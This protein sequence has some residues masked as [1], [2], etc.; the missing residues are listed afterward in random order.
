VHALFGIPV[1]DEGDGAGGN[2]SSRV[3]AGSYKGR[4][5]RR[6]VIFIVDEVGMLH[7]D[8][9][10]A[11]NAL[12]KMLHDTSVRFGRVLMIFTGDVRQIMPIVPHAD[13]LGQR[14]A[15]ASFFFSGHR[16]HCE[17]FTLTVN[18]RVQAGQGLFLDWQRKMGAD[19]YQHVQFPHDTR[20]ELTR[21]VCIP[22]QFGRYSEEEFIEEVYSSEVLAGPSLALTKRVLLA[23]TNRIVDY[24]NAKITRMM[25]GDRQTAIYFST[26]MPAAYNVYDPTSAVFSPENLQSI[27]SPKLPAHRL[28]LRVGMPVMCMQNL[29]VS[30]GICNGT[31]M[32]VERLDSGVV[33]CRFESRY[34]SLLHPFVPTEFSY[35]S[36]I[37]EFKRYQL[38]LRVAFS[39]TT[40]RAQGGTYD[41]VGCDT[42]HPFW[43][44]GQAYTVVSRV[45]S[46]E[47]LILLCD[48]T[49]DYRHNGEMQPTMRNV[50]HPWVSGRF[51]HLRAA[52]PAGPSDQPPRPPGPPVDAADMYDGPEF[53]FYDNQPAPDQQV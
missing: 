4:L 28:E 18:R 12:L 36:G 3:D 11:V 21:Y 14:Q 37:L 42:R 49:K 20:G 52:P 48:H 13:P 53:Q 9:V 50:V 38:P 29:D 19:L 2:I 47:G 17:V 24:Y 32:V 16:A 34:G 6:V 30:Y 33:W 7:M 41:V 51:D 40:N 27:N 22:R 31:Q 8:V 39:A 25:P 45:T 5:L 43:A 26:N 15:E 46:A 44:H 23:P 10:E 1:D 35:K